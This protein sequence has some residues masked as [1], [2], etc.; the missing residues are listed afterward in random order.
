MRWQHTADGSL[1]E[2]FQ[3]LR[4]QVDP[5][6]HAEKFLICFAG[7]TAPFISELERN[8][9]SEH[10]DSAIR[11][12]VLAEARSFGPDPIKHQSQLFRI[13]PQQPPSYRRL[14]QDCDDTGMADGSW[15]PSGSSR[16][17]TRDDIC[18]LQLPQIHRGTNNII[19]NSPQMIR[20]PKK[21]IQRLR[22]PNPGSPPLHSQHPNRFDHNIGPLVCTQPG[23]PSDPDTGYTSQTLDS[24]DPNYPTGDNI[25]V[26]RL[27]GRGPGRPPSLPSPANQH[28]DTTSPY[29]I[30]I[31]QHNNN[32][33]NNGNHTH[34]DDKNSTTAHV[35]GSSSGRSSRTVRAVADGRERRYKLVREGKGK[36]S[37]WFSL[38]T[39]G[40]KYY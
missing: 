15:S 12:E 31:A 11:N 10:L 2:A 39:Y 28:H 6:S 17:I 14:E 8:L 36:R 3:H 38:L 32:A 20:R 26:I 7:R 18:T 24:D 9:N 30:Q 23:G 35:Q 37:K 19:W 27:T 4:E 5:N 33:H 16:S 13:N 21:T 25:N 40:S 22:S 1:V 29:I 34:Y